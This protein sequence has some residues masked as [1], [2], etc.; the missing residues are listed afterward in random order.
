[1]RLDLFC[2]KKGWFPSR[3]KA[4]E[5]IQKGLV[6]VG[7][8]VVLKSAFEVAENAVVRLKDERH[9]VSRAGEKLWNFL[10]NNP[11]GIT[12]FVALDIGSS[13]GGFT[14][15]LLQK[16]AK[17]VVCVDVG[18]NQLHKSLREDCRIRL[19]EETDIREFGG[20]ITK[21][22]DVIV[23]DVSFIPIKSIFDSFK[24]RVGGWLILLF[25]PQFEVGR[26]AKRSKKGVVLDEAKIQESLQIMKDF[27]ENH[28]FKVA[29]CEES[30]PSG[31]EGNRE[32][33]IACQRIK[34]C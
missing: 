26:E 7:D 14:Q 18:K 28:G 5:S 3:N 34:N 16:G 24:E 20:R 2:V 12:D 25:K 1:M 33:F 30:T 23:C 4:Q 27:L 15:V 11:L 22:F 13:T 21:E 6:L 17:E 19:F 32:F 10:E 8:C 29:K 31:K 9:F